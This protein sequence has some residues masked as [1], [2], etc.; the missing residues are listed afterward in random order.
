M[1]GGGFS[2]ILRERFEPRSRSGIFHSHSIISN[3]QHVERIEFFPKALEGRLRKMIT[4]YH[5]RTI[6]YPQMPNVFQIISEGISPPLN[7]T[8]NL[9]PSGPPDQAQSTEQQQAEA[10]LLPAILHRL[11][12]VLP[13]TPSRSNSMTDSVSLPASFKLNYGR[14]LESE[15]F[16]NI[17]FTTTTPPD[18]GNPEFTPS[19]PEMESPAASGMSDQDAIPFVSPEELEIHDLGVPDHEEQRD[20][21]VASEELEVPWRGISTPYISPTIGATAVEIMPEWPLT[22]TPIDESDRTR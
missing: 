15:V 8:S 9:S 4:F 21:S 5:L 2:V 16:Q 6:L 10:R 18:D 7:A 14:W 20:D 13:S 1:L 22:P 3:L 12:L 19:P 11:P 17:G